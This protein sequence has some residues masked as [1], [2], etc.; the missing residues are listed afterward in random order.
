MHANTHAQSL[1]YPTEEAA[2]ELASALDVEARVARRAVVDARVAGRAPPHPP[3]AHIYLMLHK[4]VPAMCSRKT[5]EPGSFN[6]R[7]IYDVL[8]P[9]GAPAVP[10]VGRLDRDTSG[11]LL[12]TDDGVLTNRL[13]NKQQR[14]GGVDGT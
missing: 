6:H 5:M 13:L 1:P 2:A 11:L 14:R 4:P 9:L 8:L 7:T 3:Q 12:L 10:H